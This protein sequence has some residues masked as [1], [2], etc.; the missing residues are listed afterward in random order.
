MQRFLFRIAVS[1]SAR[2]NTNRKCMKQVCFLHGLCARCS[3]LGVQCRWCACVLSIVS[4]S[5]TSKICTELHSAIRRG[6][7]STVYCTAA[8]AR[9]REMFAHEMKNLW[10]CRCNT[11]AANDQ[12]EFVPKSLHVRCPQRSSTNVERTPET[13]N[14]REKKRERGCKKYCIFSVQN[15]FFR[16]KQP[17]FLAV[18]LPLSPSAS[19]SMCTFDG[20]VCLPSCAAIEM[21]NYCLFWS[22]FI[23]T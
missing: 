12:S 2:K 20:L 1:C 23:L 5:N 15:I 11:H 7:C 8:L 17:R 13:I 3:A 22:P 21:K 14:C 10:R 4:C 9:E 19:A 16:F 6:R 18:T